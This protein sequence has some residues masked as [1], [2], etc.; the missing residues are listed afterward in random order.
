[1]GGWDFR[2]VRKNDRTKPE[3]LVVEAEE[4]FTEEER[5]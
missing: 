3:E 1:V 2:L 5:L 4:K